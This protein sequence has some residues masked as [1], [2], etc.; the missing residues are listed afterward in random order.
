MES[1]NSKSNNS[2]KVKFTTAKASV[3]L[4]KAMESAIKNMT[5]EAKNI[6]LGGRKSPDGN[7]KVGDKKY[8]VVSGDNSSSQ[9]FKLKNY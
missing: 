2:R 4:I 7:V 5:S 8:R 6:N 3:D 1:A 9:K